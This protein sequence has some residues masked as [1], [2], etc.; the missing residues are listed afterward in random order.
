MFH[1][2]FFSDVIKVK[3]VSPAVKDRK[4]ESVTSFT[5]CQVQKFICLNSVSKT[6]SLSIELIGVGYV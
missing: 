4:L 3:L 2:T 6:E 5:V 1:K